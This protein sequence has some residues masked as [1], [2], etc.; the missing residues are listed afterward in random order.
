MI[1]DLLTYDGSARSTAQ[2][3]VHSA[4]DKLGMVATPAAQPGQTLT[5]G[6]PPAPSCPWRIERD[7]WG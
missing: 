6:Q 4:G 5:S 7:S 1:R 2:A 3:V